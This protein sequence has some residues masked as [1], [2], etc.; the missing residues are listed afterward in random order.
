MDKPRTWR[1]I[2][3]SDVGILI[4]LGL[5]KIILHTSPTVSTVSI[6]TN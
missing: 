5:T 1:D 6:E 4:L 2:L 3:F